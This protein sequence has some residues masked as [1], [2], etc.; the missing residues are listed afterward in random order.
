MVK[1]QKTIDPA[2]GKTVN[3]HAEKFQNEAGQ[4]FK[5]VGISDM[6]GN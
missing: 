4:A 1:W 5:R 2:T 6:E 3:F